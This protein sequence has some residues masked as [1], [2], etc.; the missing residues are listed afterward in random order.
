[1]GFFAVLGLIIVLLIVLVAEL[2]NGW[3]DAPNAIT[4]VVVTRVLSLRQ[5][6]IMAAVG[7]VIGAM[8]FGE[9]VAQTIGKEIVDASAINL[10]TVFSAMVALILWSSFAATRGVPTSESHGL[11][12]GL[13]GGALYV[14]GADLL[15]VGGWIKVGIGLVVPIFLAGVLAYVLATLVIKTCAT[16]NPA[17]CKRFFSTVQIFTAAGMA[18]AHGMN[19]GMKFIGVFS[20]A[21]HLGGMTPEVIIA[22]WIIVLCAFVMGV[23]TWFGG[24]T[25]IYK[26]GCQMTTLE[27]WQGCS[28]E[29]AGAIAIVLATMFG[30]P[31]STTHSANMAIMGAGRARGAHALN[32]GAGWGLVRAR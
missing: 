14:G 27:N 7:N 16:R 15:L 24:A 30:I 21:W 23:G 8:F 29:L 20:L 19:D 25:I 9:K 12:A 2:V 4:S 6:I 26:T 17:R 28:A 32:W 1:M 18:W 10:E 5:A 31:L 11:V 3:T 13:T 22:P